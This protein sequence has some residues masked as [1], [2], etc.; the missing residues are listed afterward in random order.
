MSTA[1]TNSAPDDCDEMTA[2]N[3]ESVAAAAIY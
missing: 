1:Q 3:E 2:N